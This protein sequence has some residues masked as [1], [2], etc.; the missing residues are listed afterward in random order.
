MA[1]LLA[2]LIALLTGCGSHEGSAEGADRPEEG[3]A[4][5]KVE[6]P[7]RAPVWSPGEQAVFALGQDGRRLVKVDVTG[8]GFTPDERRPEAVAS[9]QKLD[10]AAGENLALERDR[11]PDKIYVPIPDRDEIYVSEKD[12]LLKVQTFEAGESPAQVALGRSSGTLFALSEDGSTV[13]A[14]DLVGKEVVAQIRV[15]GGEGAN[16]GIS[17]VKGERG[18]WVAGSVGVGFYE[19][20][21]FERLA[22]TPIDAGVLAVSDLTPERAY[23][24]EASPR[25]IVAIQLNSGHLEVVAEAGVDGKVT[26]LAPEKG[27]LYAVTPNRILVLDPENLRTLETLEFDRFLDR[28]ALERAEPSG[29]AVGGKN[30]YLTFEGEPFLVQIEKP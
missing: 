23:A 3:A 8:G 4:V 17:E 5:L 25:R 16:L 28:E 21:S 20:S 30:L 9:S 29:L 7:L 18:L 24:S 6:S 19:G 1:A 15:D 10:G 11:A 2:G 22:R 12:D 14:V 27:R 26:H 13:T